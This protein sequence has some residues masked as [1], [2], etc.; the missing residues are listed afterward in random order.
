MTEA[1][2]L[3]LNDRKHL[4]QGKKEEKLGGFKHKTL[5]ACKNIVTVSESLRK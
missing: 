4:M 5:I 3:R 1:D 2:V